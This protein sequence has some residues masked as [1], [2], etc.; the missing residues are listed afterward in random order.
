MLEN[1]LRF[2]KLS[3]NGKTNLALKNRVRKM[4]KLAERDK[5]SGT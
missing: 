3:D 1:L 2:E 4:I 5:S